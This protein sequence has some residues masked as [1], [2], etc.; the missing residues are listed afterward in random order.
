MIAT[1]SKFFKGAI[2]ALAAIPLAAAAT[3]TPAGSAQ[4]AVLTGQAAYS[5]IGAGPFSSV[6]TIL[7]SDGTIEFSTPNLVGL[8]LQTGTFASKGLTAATIYDVSSIPGLFDPS[9]LFLDFGNDASSVVDGNNVFKATSASNYVITTDGGSG[10]S[11]ALSFRGYFLGDDETQISSGIV[12]L[13]FTSMMSVADVTDVLLNNGVETG[14]TT[15]TSTFS[16]LAVASTPEP[17][18]LLGLGIVAAGMAVS[19]RRKTIPA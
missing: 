12:N 18:T 17:A 3:F 9:S 11:I 16:G 13:N 4:A 6:T 10:S 2:A 7:A 14:I 15:I 1:Q 8:S 5:G 19:R